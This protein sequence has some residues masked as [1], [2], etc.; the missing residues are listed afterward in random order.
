MISKIRASDKEES[1]LETNFEGMIQKNKFISTHYIVYFDQDIE[2][3]ENYRE[4]FH[5]LRHATEWDVITFVLN[6]DGGEVD[7]SLQLYDNITK[8]LARTRVELHKAVSA[9]T[10][11]LLAVDEVE[12][13]IFPHV[14]IHAYSW[15]FEGKVSETA[16]R[17]EFF[18]KQVHNTMNTIYKGFLSSKEI[19][20]CYNG[21]D[22]WLTKNE[23]EKRLKNFYKIR[24]KKN[25]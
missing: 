1:N 13:C 21:K 8:T 18:E 11:I 20:A 9:A 4:L 5:V 10:F 2:G 12:L 7:L 6:C 16:A 25:V 14:M 17:S 3:A 19:E 24:N 15:G 23:I 22:L